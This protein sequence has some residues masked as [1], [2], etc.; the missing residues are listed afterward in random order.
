MIPRQQCSIMC[1]DDSLP[2]LTRLQTTLVASGFDVETAHN[3]FAALMQLA[4]HPTRF[5]VV[6]T[7]LRMPGM[8]GFTLIERIKASGYSGGIIVFSGAI[9]QDDQFRLRELRV[10][11]V[12]DK[13]G[14]PGEIVDAVREVRLVA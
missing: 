7:D 12:I 6:I 11:R 2:Q 14:H 3:G 1:V 9:A 13:P 4:Q 10:H 5:Q 8:D